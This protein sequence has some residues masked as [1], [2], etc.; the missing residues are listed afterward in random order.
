MIKSNNDDENNHIDAYMIFTLNCHFLGPLPLW[1]D[2]LLFM[3]D[4]LIAFQQFGT[5][6][7]LN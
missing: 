6:A 7:F 2:I 1:S 4:P 3:D 5:Q